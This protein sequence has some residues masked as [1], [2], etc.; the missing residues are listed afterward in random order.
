MKTKEYLIYL[1]PAALVTGPLVSEMII[2]LSSLNI[3][4]LSIKNNLTYLYKN[5]F[6]YIFFFFI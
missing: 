3:I 1:L 5:N 6:S 4:Y 2:I